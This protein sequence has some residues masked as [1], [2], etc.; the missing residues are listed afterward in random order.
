MN[1]KS[2]L[3]FVAALE[4]L[5]TGCSPNEKTSVQ[6]KDLVDAVF[7]SGNIVTK[8]RYLIS[9]QS[10]GYL[11]HS[12]AG[13]GDS[14]KSGE[15]LFQLQDET[16]KA[17]LESAESAYQKAQANLRTSSPVLQKLDQQKMQVKNQLQNDSVN[18]SRYQNLIQTNAV[19]KADFDR[20]KLAYEN[21]QSEYRAIQNTIEDTRRNL[22][23]DLVNARA[24]LV[25]QQENSVN[26]LLTSKVDGMLLQC[27]K[28]EGE[29]IKR[30]E[31]IAEIGSGAF[32]ARLQVAEDDI[33]RVKEG[34][35]VYI[36]LNTN[37]NHACQARISK[38]YPAFDTDE[39]SFIAEA[40]FTGQVP[41][42][43]SGTQLQSN[44]VV[45]EKKNALVI[46]SDYL[47]PGQQV[48]SERHNMGIKVMT[49]IQTPEWVEITGGLKEGDMIEKRKL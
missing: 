24:N 3:Y 31:A 17:Q 15:L 37:R 6:R 48:F 29:L 5:V 32:I 12:F 39:Q 46:P 43:K 21:S 18:F 27:F 1:S 40:V 23:L 10:E 30:G 34:Q 7:A 42:L 28:E 16:P 44:I 4:I 41:L 20:I 13:E 14:V 11:Q 49:G 25:A 22:R 38:V 33:N 2:I 19:S 47:Q 36:E 35:T 45:A 9:S 26:F 8:D